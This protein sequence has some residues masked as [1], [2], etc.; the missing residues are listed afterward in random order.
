MA[1]PPPC[2]KSTSLSVRYIGWW[3][4]PGHRQNT[5]IIELYEADNGS[6][7][8]RPNK[9]LDSSL[10]VQQLEIRGGKTSALTSVEKD[11][12]IVEFL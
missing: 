4:S 2:E 6:D 10:N 1:L 5:D 9:R 3:N 12:V 7:E 11:N 8:G